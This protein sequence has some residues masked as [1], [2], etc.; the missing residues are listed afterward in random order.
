MSDLIALWGID[1]FQDALAGSLFTPTD[2]RSTQSGQLQ[3]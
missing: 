3:D 1:A 2:A